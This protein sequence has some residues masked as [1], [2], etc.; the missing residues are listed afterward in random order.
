MSA[1]GLTGRA[2]NLP[3]ELTTFVGRAAELV[4]VGGA[5]AR[6]RLVTLA[7]PGGVGKTRL[8]LRAAGQA[9]G[10]FADGVWLVELDDL[11]DPALLAHTVADAL[12]IGERSTRAPIDVL[13]DH[14]SSR[15]ALLIL[16]SCEHLVVA[17]AALADQVLRAAPDLKILATSRQALRIAGE[18]IYPVSPLAAWILQSGGASVPPNTSQIP[19]ASSSD[20]SRI[21][22]LWGL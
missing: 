5:L 14:L 1:P 9:A 17:V 22:K 7:G 4:A 10:A 3:A 18:H 12:G 21:V 11:D 15:N 19:A 20:S 13:C 2:G 6:S 8:A 16:D